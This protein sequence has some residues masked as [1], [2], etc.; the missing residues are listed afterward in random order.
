[1]QFKKSTGRTEQGLQV[2]FQ[3]LR[4]DTNTFRC[5]VL[6]IKHDVCIR[7]CQCTSSCLYAKPQ[8]LPVTST[9]VSRLRRRYRPINQPFSC[10]SL[11]LPTPQIQGCRLSAPRIIISN[12]P[13]LVACP[14]K[15]PGRVSGKLSVALVRCMLFSY[16]ELRGKLF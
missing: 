11:P 10:R 13:K 8:T 1:M 3:V 16:L 2:Q 5:T 15:R 6:S 12:P 7:T 4:S 9:R 14:G